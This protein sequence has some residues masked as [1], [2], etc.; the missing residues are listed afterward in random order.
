MKKKI[1]SKEKKLLAWLKEAGYKAA[2]NDWF[3]AVTVLTQEFQGNDL[4]ET[5][6]HFG[7]ADSHFDLTGRIYSDGEKEIRIYAKAAA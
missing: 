7:F 4:L 6:R 5:M 1:N 3:R 2:Y